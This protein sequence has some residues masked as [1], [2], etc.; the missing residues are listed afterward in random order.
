MMKLRSKEDAIVKNK[1][2]IFKLVATFFCLIKIQ[3]YF[4]IG[5][6]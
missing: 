5:M 3:L 6:I 4:L 1:K 2:S